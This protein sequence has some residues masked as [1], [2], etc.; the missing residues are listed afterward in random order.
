M[1]DLSLIRVAAV[2]PKLRIADIEYNTDVIIS[3]ISKAADNNCFFTVFPELSLTGYSCQDLFFQ[4][5]LLE[6]VKEALIQI[7]RHTEFAKTTCIIGAPLSSSGRLFNTA[8]F[9]SNGEIKG[10]VPKTYLCNNAEYYEKRWFASENDRVDTDIKLNYE[11]IPFGA[12]IL[13]VSDDDLNLRI[14]IEICED[15]WAVNPPS[16]DMALAGA[17]LF[18]NLSASNEFIGKSS[19]RD[20]LVKS[21]SA[22][23]LSAYIYSAAGANE[24]TADTVFSGHSMIYENGK[25]M[26]EGKK[27]SFDSEI[28]YTDIDI[29]LLNSERM[30][31]TSFISSSNETEY[32]IVPF[33]TNNR[34]NY[35][36]LRS[37]P[38]HP[39]VPDNPD[40]LNDICTE[41]IN[42]QSTG[43]AR[44][45]K[46]INAKTAVIGISG[47]LDSTLALLVTY[48]AF[49][50]LALDMAGIIAV[51]MP[52]LGTSEL[53]R[54]NAI[55]LAKN[56][57]VTLKNIDII[58]S[59]R[60]HFKDIEHDENIKD[61]VYENAQARRRTHILMDLANKHNGL[62]VGTGNLSEIALGWSTFNADHIS[63]YNVNSSVPK[64]LVKYLIKWY[65]EN[66]FESPISEV[67]YS[68]MET[69]ISPELLPLDE[70]MQIV[71]KTEDTIGPY[72]LHD[73]FLYHMIRLSYPPA[74]TA[75]FAE[76]AFKGQYTLAEIQK[77]LRVFIKR[78]FS[79]QFKRNVFSEG[80]KVGTVSLSPR[81][82][83][84]MPSEAQSSI[85]LDRNE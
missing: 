4:Q 17:N 35:N 8:V 32:R 48:A 19:Y 22:K 13:F 45:L 58:E 28:I 42:I 64:T 38:K 34:N 72:E 31:N 11:L 59:V 70:N 61:I 65:A 27:F 60:S 46:H 44:R 36:I 85:W 57:E 83:W 75:I 77:H 41:I 51:N 78:F 16:C 15:L 14:G 84:R 67:L 55:S 49:K 10:I 39:F 82:D 53:T 7:A 68:I 6:K 5:I 74:K 47:G 37:I 76:K 73:F 56:L 25:L 43:L 33:E 79:Q 30:K 9:I 50:K 52:G 63:M 24:S 26:A 2:T 21:Q 54:N 29:A 40:K 80:P 23:L 20:L 66:V 71:Q 12:D 1:N 69:P 3:C 81:A 62:V 18:C